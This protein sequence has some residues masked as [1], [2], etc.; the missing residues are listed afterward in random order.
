MGTYQARDP[1]AVMNTLRSTPLV[2]SISGLLDRPVH[3]VAP[4]APLGGAIAG[5]APPTPRELAE[6]ALRNAEA[7]LRSAERT[8]TAARRGIGE[9]NRTH[10][11]GVMSRG[12]VLMP[13][14]PFTP[15]RIRERKSVA[16]RLL[17]QRRADLRAAM[18]R[19]A[20]ARA[21]LAAHPA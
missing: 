17:N 12:R 15:E 1:R 21:A 19:V 2:R 18:C 7:E 9:A 16:F 11:A 6:R 14:R 3:P 5:I 20:E 4:V 13:P 8:Y 10:T